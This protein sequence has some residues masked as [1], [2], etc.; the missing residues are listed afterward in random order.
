MSLLKKNKCY[1]KQ[2]WNKYYTLCFIAISK[3]FSPTMYPRHD[4]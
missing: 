4:N 1:Y 3:Y 2:I